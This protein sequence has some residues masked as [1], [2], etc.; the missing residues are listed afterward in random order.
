MPSGST[1]QQQELDWWWSFDLVHLDP[2]VNTAPPQ[3]HASLK[4][5]SRDYKQ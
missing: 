3:Q 4:Q 5:R 2:A 1:E